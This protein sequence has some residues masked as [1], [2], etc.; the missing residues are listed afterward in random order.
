[1]G[2]LIRLVV[3]C[4]RSTTSLAVTMDLG[5][6]ILLLVV[7]CL[8]G[9]NSETLKVSSTGAAARIQASKMGN[10]VRTS[11]SP[12]NGHPV[13]K[14]TG[15]VENFL[16]VSP[17]GF[18]TVGRT[19]GSTTSGLYNPQLPTP[20]TPPTSGW[21]YSDLPNGWKEDATLKVEASPAGVPAA[22]QSVVGI[23]FI[24]IA[25]VVPG[26][27]AATT[28][29]APPTTTTTTTTA[30]PAAVDQRIIGIL[31]PLSLGILSP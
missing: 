13:Y 9:A 25:A 12:V 29:A 19:V 15:G 16:Y 24:P 6:V 11:R 20:S 10:Y 31:S 14:K 8:V 3:K 5:Q 26:T 21:L 2:L 30:A 4:V 22:D 1:M 23:R 17:N 7:S 18:W 27:R 28:T